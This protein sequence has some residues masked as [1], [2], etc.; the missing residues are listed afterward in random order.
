VSHYLVWKDEDG[1]KKGIKRDTQAWLDSFP[2]LD[3][4]EVLVGHNIKFD[5]LWYWRHPE[6]EKFLLRGGRIWDTLYAEY[7]LSG[8]FYHVHQLPYLRPSLHNVAKRRG[9]QAKLDVVGSLWEQGIRT[10]D[11]QEQILMEYLEGDCVTTEQIFEQQMAQA[12]RQNQLH[13]IKG[14]MEGLLATTEMEFNGL[15]IDLIEAESRLAELNAEV[16]DL[17]DQLQEYVPA[18]PDGCEFNWGSSQQLS[19]LLFG[20]CLKYKAPVEKRDEAGNLMYYQKKVRRELLDKDNNPIIIKSGKNKGRVKTKIFTEPDIER[21]PKTRLEDHF[22][23][24]PGLVKGKLK[25]RTQSLNGLGGPIYSTAADILEEVNSTHDVPLLRTLLDLRGLEKDIGTYYRRYYNG[26][27]TGMLT[28]VH[29][30]GRIH[31]NLNHTVTLTSRLSSSKPNL[32]N[33]SGQGKSQVR[34]MF[35][36]RFKNGTM[37][38]SDYG[39][40][41]VVCKG[42]L[43]QDWTLLKALI[44]GVDF[45]CDWLALSPL[46]EGKPYEEIHR[47]CK[48]EHDPR[49]VSKRKQIKPLTFGE[50]Y[51]AGTKSLCESTGMTAEQ[52]EAAVAARK[53][54][55]YRTYEYDDQNIAKVKASRKPSQIMTDGGFQAGIGYLRSATDTIYHFVETDSPEWMQKRGIHTSFSPTTIKNYPSQGLGGEIMQ[56]QLGRLFRWVLKM[57]TIVDGFRDGFLLVNTVHDCVWTDCKPEFQKYVAELEEILEDVCDYFNQNYPNVD[58]NTPFPVETESGPNMYDL[59]VVER[60]H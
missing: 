3:G 34:K 24:L 31:H 54:K 60:T 22:F 15:F 14:R 58:W 23:E 38:E 39:Q 47:L 18:M 42:V 20:G 57:S 6:L 9:V 55:Y 21:G 17:T 52:I 28:M 16:E 1:T 32:Q 30:D 35:K 8:Q 46:G 10:E 48:V 2:C 41:E 59:S 49:W 56:V 53:A 45:H 51:G 33:L 13:M 25:W 19:A 44:D 12:I 27:W 43:A 7:L 40:L 4:V 36:S 29:P 50:S 5:L 11:I 37:N 26:K